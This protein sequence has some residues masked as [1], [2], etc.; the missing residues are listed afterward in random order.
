MIA[1][2]TKSEIAFQVCNYILLTIL[3][4]CFVIPY[5]IIIMASFTSSAA[6]NANGYSLWPQ[7]W[8]VEAYRILFGTAQVWHSIKSSVIITV[9][10]VAFSVTGTSLVA[11]VMSKRDLI[12]RSSI[13]NVIIFAML[14]SGGVIPGYILMVQ[15]GLKNSYFAFILPSTLSIWNMILIRSYFDTIPSTIEEAAKIDGCRHFRIYCQIFMPLSMPILATIILFTAVGAWN[16]W[17]APKLYIDT[18]HYKTMMPLT[19][20]LRDILQSAS[21]QEGVA[22]EITEQNGQ[23][24]T[25]VVATLPIILVYPFLQKYFVKGIMLG[26]VK[27]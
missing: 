11:Y 15:L 4:L 26:S 19:P 24:A 27:G 9:G 12:G 18:D 1:G 25:V 14:F 8:S 17:L 21:A 23:M 7:E 20:W 16:N 2:R 6:M 10:T 3:G 13:M 5:W 22:P